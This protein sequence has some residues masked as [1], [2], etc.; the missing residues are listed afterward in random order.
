MEQIRRRV[1]ISAAARDLDVS[2]ETVRLWLAGG[3]LEGGRDPDSGLL[4]VSLDSLARLKAARAARHA[5]AA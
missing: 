1:R 4:L 5:A 3:R 2:L